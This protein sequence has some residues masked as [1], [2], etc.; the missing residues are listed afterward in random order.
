MMTMFKR[1]PN[2][3][4]WRLLAATAALTALFAASSCQTVDAPP[5]APAEKTAE[6]PPKDPAK[7]AAWKLQEY[8]PLLPDGAEVITDSS[9]EFLQVPAWAEDLGLDTSRFTVAKT[10]PTIDFMYFPEQNQRGNPWSDWGDGLAIDGKYYAGIGDH[11]FKAYVYEYDAK[12]KKLRTLVDIAKFLDLPQGHY[13]PGKVHSRIDMG[14]DGWLYFTTHRGSAKYTTDAYHFKGDWLFRHQPQTGKTEI[15]AAGPAGKES[16]PTGRLDPERMIYY[17]GTQQNNIFAAVDAATGKVLYKS[18]PNGG[19][20]RYVVLSSSTGRVYYTGK[21]HVENKTVACFDPATRTVKEIPGGFNIRSA[22]RELP[23]GIVY[24]ND[25]Q[26]NLY[27][28]DVKQE[29]FAKIGH[30]GII[31]TDSKQWRGAYVTSLDADPSGRYLYYTT[32]AHGGLARMGS[33]IMQYDTK[34]NKKKVIAFVN[35][36]YAKKCGYA[37]DGSFGSDVSR[38]GSTLYITMNG[39]RAGEGSGSRYWWACA[40]FVIHIPVSERPI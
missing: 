1:S 3:R 37:A 20:Y 31:K 19:P 26:G 14:K 32:H 40:L 35:N 38:D 34:T 21:K 27:R 25:W 28:F 23:G 24:V 4:P 5:E 36:F 18:A 29:S 39:L 11:A 10:P 15:V 8:P 13:L 17:A 33:P 2:S 16:L 9:P 12:T 22:T 30:L 6:T 7:K